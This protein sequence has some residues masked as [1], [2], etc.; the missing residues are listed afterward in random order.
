MRTLLGISLILNLVL[1]VFWWVNAKREAA[2]VSESGV[3]PPGASAP[4]SASRN[5][6]PMETT[7]RPHLE[8]SGMAPDS[9][10]RARRLDWREIES[11]HYPEYVKRLRQAGVPEAIIGDLVIADVRKAFAP[12]GQA[13]LGTNWTLH[14]WQK[15]AQ[16]ALNPDQVRQLEA[17]EEQEQA[18]LSELLGRKITLQPLV[19]QL[20]L[21]IDSRNLA[22]GF[23]PSEVQEKA[24]AALE[25]A[26]VRHFEMNHPAFAG[27]MDT[28]AD[29]LRNSR[30][31]EVLSEVLTPDELAQY[32]ARISPNTPELTHRTRYMDVT[33]SEF[34]RL[35]D[36]RDS[37]AGADPSQRTTRERE[38]VQ[39]ILGPE[40]AAEFEKSLD[41]SYMY[42]R[43]LARA[44]GLPDSAGEDV[45]R[46]RDQT[47]AEAARIQA[48]TTDAS[49][50]SAQLDALR[51]RVEQTLTTAF[52]PE[53]GRMILG[54][55]PWVSVL[56]QA[57]TPAP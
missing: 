39:A 21:Q 37:L 4:S 18:V 32:R 44:Q 28:E 29:L 34:M 50:R 1:A 48:S 8:G 25:N 47:E 51:Q 55:S 17:L 53:G 41:D 35:V 6:V 40:R 26:G 38:A 2:K 33:E 31:L 11:T 52:G 22:L 46:L 43:E 20:F 15:P 12:Q 16:H 45:R 13:I 57:G 9:N 49:Q 5:R 7:T 3:P 36:V 23:L 30:R 19:D 56:G 10:P 14:Y 54:V 27:T 24:L 42:A